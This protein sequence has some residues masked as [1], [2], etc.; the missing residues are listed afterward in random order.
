MSGSKRWRRVAIGLGCAAAIGGWVGAQQTKPVFVPQ[1]KETPAVWTRSAS[2]VGNTPLAAT[3]PA[4]GILPPIPG[5]VV[6]AVPKSPGAD[7]ATPGPRVP[8]VPPLPPGALPAIPTAPKPPELKPADLPPLEPV[9]PRP[10]PAPAA[11]SLPS[12]PFP[13]P[14]LVVV[15]PPTPIPVIPQPAAVAPPP[16]AVES[17][18]PVPPVLP[19]K[20]DFNLRPDVPGNSVKSN[21]P[22]GEPAKLPTVPPPVELTQ[23]PAIPPASRPEPPATPVDR[24][25]TAES[26]FGTP[27][28]FAVPLP[29]AP[30]IPD[31]PAP[32]PGDRTMTTTLKQ[33]TLAAVIGGTLAFA[34]AKPANAFP[35]PVGVEQKEKT[36]EEKV[37]DLQKDTKRIL[38]LLEGRK[39]ESGF[40]IPTSP[41]LAAELRKLKDD[42]AALDAKL[43]EIEKNSTSLRPA[44]PATPAPATTPRGTVRVVNDYPVMISILVN[45]TSHRIEPQKSLDI[46]V[47][48]GEFTY[49]LLQS[50]AAAVKSPIKDKEVVTLRVK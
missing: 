45:G 22:N 31:T 4:S 39:D 47:P 34:P 24:P 36:L 1:T 40:P 16:V 49:Q 28:T 14:N 30:K 38:E 41:G 27:G 21:T 12:A 20:P 8:D 32:T 6:P 19:P 17:A 18:V 11:P 26:P 42:V 2:P 15:P 10:A 29:A 43:K 13:T 44:N 5:I 35:V 48:A 50:G 25:R 46:G 37:A 9:K 23:I 3:V 7:P 33:T